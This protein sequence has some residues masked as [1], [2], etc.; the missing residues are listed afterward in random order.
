VTVAALAL[1][2]ALL[3]VPGRPGRRFGPSRSQARTGR[4]IVLVGSAAGAAAIAVVAPVTVTVAA[5]VIAATFAVRRNGSRR[6]AR[7]AAESVALQGALGVLVGELRVGAHPVVAFESAA[8]EVEGTVAQS[9]RAVAARARLG[10]DVAAG[11]RSVAGHSTVPTYWERLSVCWQLAQ[12]QGLS[13]VA[14]V[15]AAQLDIVERERFASGVSA[16]MAGARATAAILAGLPVVGVGL[17][18]LIGAAPLRFL[19]SGGVGGWLLLV[20]VALACAGLWWSDR[21]TDRVL[22]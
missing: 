5:A 19:L 12:T 10:A 1:A 15:R 2:L 4:S 6:R 18:H 13:I 20:G 17:G 14:L 3:V 7:R 22:R 9:L 11:L 16:G 8:A 21:I